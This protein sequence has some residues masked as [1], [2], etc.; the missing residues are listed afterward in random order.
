MLFA[1][2]GPGARHSRIRWD[3]GWRLTCL[4]AGWVVVCAAPLAGHIVLPENLH[5]AAAAYRQCTF[6]LNL[7]PVPWDEVRRDATILESHLTELDAAVGREFDAAYERVLDRLKGSE[8]DEAA[9]PR[10]EWEAARRTV[11]EVCTRAVA[12]VVVGHLRAA[13]AAPNREGA[14]QHLATAREVFRAFD[15]ALPHVDPPGYQRLGRAFVAAT[16]AMGSDGLLRL[17]ARP[18]DRAAFQ[19]H[20]AVVVE[21]VDRNF[22]DSFRAGPEQ[23]LLPRPQAS[24]TYNASAKVPVRLPPAADI[25]KQIPRPRQILG[26]AA[27]GVNEL[28]TPLIAL[29]DMAFDSAYIFGEPARSMS[30]SCNTCHNKSITNP[31]FFIPGLSARPGGMDVSNSFFAPH[32][33]NAHF[34]PLDIPDLRGIRFTAPYGRNGRFASL[35]EFVRNVIVGEF[36]GPEPDPLLMDAI[37][38]YMNEFEFLP[39]PQLQ[40]DGRLTAD[41]PAAARRGEAIFARPFPQM[42]GKSCATCHV[43]SNHFLDGMRH[44]IGSVAGSEPHSRDRALD[45]PTLLSAKYTAP[46][47]HD[48]RL[49]TLR[50]VNEWFNDRYRLEL[51]SRELDDLTAYVEVVSDGVDAYE[52]TP[53]YL[54][55]EMEEFSFFLGA[56][57][58]LRDRNKTGLAATTC[59]T[60]SLEI[61]NHK[62][63]LRDLAFLPVMDQLA[64][65]IDDA[66]DACL[67]GDWKTADTKVAAYRALYAKNVENL[68]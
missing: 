55:A 63:E 21:Y 4:A 42:G 51:S 64:D 43:P 52:V 37:I 31:Q 40:A 54:D 36:N 39:N 47:F 12:E 22:G 49:P 68:K 5:P 27:R 33:N 18:F 7:T 6:L 25:N 65:L 8:E 1:R 14:G 16:D 19:Q 24:A 29:G 17:G 46:Y 34:D 41:A 59:R 15:V 35:R 66:Y 57:E 9:D 48:G 23:R 44:D 61:R 50:L 45:T 32:A 53:Y 38:A 62:W 30:I 3:T 20:V 58:F 26:M 56:Y 13:A 11:F 67:A 10:A 2:R 28:D 60:V